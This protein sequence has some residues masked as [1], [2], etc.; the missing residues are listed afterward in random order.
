MLRLCIL[1]T[2]DDEDLQKLKLKVNPGSKSTLD[3]PIQDLVQLLFDIESMQNALIE[4]EVS[5]L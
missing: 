5:N 1:I 3:K 2:Q 4:F